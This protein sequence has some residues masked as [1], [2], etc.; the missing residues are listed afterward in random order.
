MI[1]ETVT[2]TIY[3]DT[4]KGTKA[5]TKILAYDGDDKLYG[6]GGNDKLYGHGDN[7]E[8]YGGGDSDYL[9]GGSGKDTMD[10]GDGKDTY[11]VDNIGDVT[12][13]VYNDGPGGV[14]TVKASANHTI[15]NGIENLN[16]TGVGNIKGHGNANNNVING[17]SGNNS[18]NGYGGDDTIKAGAGNDNV[19]GG[20][21]NDYIDGW[22]GNDT[23]LGFS[24][25]D[26]ILGYSGDDKLNGESGDDSLSGGSGND[27]L[28]GGTGKDTMDGG[29]GN[30]TYIVDNT[31]DVTKE[32]YNDGLGGVDTVNASAN[33]TIGNGIENL[34]LT[35]GGNINGYGNAN[36]NVINGNSG[37]NWLYGGTGK[38]TLS[39]GAGKDTFDFD[40]VNESPAWGALDTISD[41]SWI[42]GDKID[43]STIDAGGDGSFKPEQLS[44]N[45]STGVLT[46]DVYGG[47]DLQ[48]TV[49]G[50]D[51][52]PVAQFST[53][54][55]IIP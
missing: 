6:H 22:T 34:N 45:S 33:H 24:G 4:L 8:L 39:G 19:D 47:D 29:D 21:G 51:G 44:Y 31:G 50:V 49:V 54:L 35:G 10:G 53:S 41:F 46:A 36:N 30:D 12:K 5:D 17:N 38:D 48:V 18:L 14:D 13:E 55:D 52:L 26:T 25:N 23:L 11:I 16:L 9:D 28:N 27:Y 37:N 32:V 20:T 15:G 7:D 2:G 3:N 40:S 42:E 43:L 1:M